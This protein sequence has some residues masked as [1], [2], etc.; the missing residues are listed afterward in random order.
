[1]TGPMHKGPH[2]LPLHPPQAPKHQGEA[3]PGLA[4]MQVRPLLAINCSDLCADVQ[5]RPLLAINCNDRAVRTSGRALHA[6]GE[7]V[8]LH[9]SRNC[10]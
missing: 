5:V 6:P 10:G 9:L 8:A 4:N 3:L 1:M 7:S 2:R